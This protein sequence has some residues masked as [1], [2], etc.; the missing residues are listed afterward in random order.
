MM[1][2]M[3]F[4]WA[5]LALKQGARVSRAGWNGPGQ[6]LKLQP[7]ESGWKMTLPYIFIRTVGGDFV[8]WVASQTDMLAE[9]WM[10]AG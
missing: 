3:D 5:L 2:G 7:V 8:P 6:W 4:G 10:D 1:E 9:D